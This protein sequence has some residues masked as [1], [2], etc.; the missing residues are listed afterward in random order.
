[1]NVKELDSRGQLRLV[2][3]AI[4]HTSVSRSQQKLIHE[5]AIDS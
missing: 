2:L 1:M 4:G 5:M 3:D